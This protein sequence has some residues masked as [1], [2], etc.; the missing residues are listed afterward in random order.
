MGRDFIENEAAGTVVL[1]RF[2]GN[3]AWRAHTVD[4][5]FRILLPIWKTGSDWEE[6][7]GKAAGFY[8]RLIH[9]LLVSQFNILEYINISLFLQKKARGA[10]VYCSRF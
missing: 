1:A 3:V 2:G 9:F 5:H 8:I 6:N 7:W 10:G 4:K